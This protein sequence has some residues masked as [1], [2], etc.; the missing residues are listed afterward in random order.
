MNM[1]AAFTTEGLSDSLVMMA[2]GF[3]VVMSVLVFLFITITLIGLIFS[4]AEKKTSR[5]AAASAD[6]NLAP[7][8]DPAAGPSGL[9]ASTLALIA[10]AV[11]TTVRGP[12]RIV[13]IEQRHTSD[14]GEN[15]QVSSWSV[16]GRRAI[17][18]SHRVR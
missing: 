18:S 6:S 2:S 3:I 14:E 15:V 7:E 16:E 17:F 4:A 9:S 10:A 12:Y 8:S 1:F 5:K 11:H 13:G